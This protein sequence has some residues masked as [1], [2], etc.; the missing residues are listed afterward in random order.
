M[1]R[2]FLICSTE[3]KTGAQI[4][5]VLAVIFTRLI[6]KFACDNVPVL[7]KIKIPLKINISKFVH[8]LMVLCL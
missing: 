6:D 1:R 7:R 5:K 4:S 8:K 3:E 2:F